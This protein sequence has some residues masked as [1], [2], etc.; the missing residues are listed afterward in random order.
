MSLNRPTE[1]QHDSCDKPVPVPLRCY[2]EPES[3]PVQVCG[4]KP[5]VRR[6]IS[7]FESLPDVREKPDGPVLDVVRTLT[8]SQDEVLLIIMSKFCSKYNTDTCKIKTV[9]IN[10]NLIIRAT[11]QSE[12]DEMIQK[13]NSHLLTVERR[14]KSFE[15]AECLYLNATEPKKCLRERF[16]SNKINAVISVDVNTSILECKAF[17]SAV[18]EKAFK[19]IEEN[20]VTRCIQLHPWQQ[21]MRL[22]SKSNLTG[23]F[24]KGQKVQIVSF[25]EDKCKAEYY[26]IL[27]ELRKKTSQNKTPP[28]M[29]TAPLVEDRP[30]AVF[31]EQ[32]RALVVLKDGRARGFKHWLHT[33]IKDQLR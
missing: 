5:V 12:I 30:V 16:K 2:Q 1:D 13:I 14:D 26:R 32:K 20:L 29:T 31:V 10:G 8:L 28:H 22:T 27:N 15:N 25:F 17:F 6:K 23:V 3:S 18:V 11:S 7:H 4:V 19:Y 24:M 9:E 33:S 21:N